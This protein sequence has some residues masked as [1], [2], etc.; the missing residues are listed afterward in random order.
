MTAS[1][2]AAPSM[3]TTD[4]T[5]TAPAEDDPATLPLGCDT[6]V[7][8]TLRVMGHPTPAGSKKSFLDRSG[9]VRTVEQNREEHE[10]WRSA[11]TRHAH[12][13]ATTLPGPLDGPM[14]L[15]ATFRFRCPA[16]RLRQARQRGG[17]L[18]MTIAPDLSKL[19][20]SI[21]DD[22]QA[23]GLIRNDARFATIFATKIEVVDGWTGVDITIRRAAW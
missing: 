2:G 20:R 19:I 6:T 5:T 22:M 14:A 10:P 23:A 8:A 3:R 18:P 21:E 1:A 15:E 4:A 16:A 12:A 9:K 13:V 17:T 11:V 7:L